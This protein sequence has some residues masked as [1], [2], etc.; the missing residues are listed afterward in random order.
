M[1]KILVILCLFAFSCQGKL[2]QE[3]AKTKVTALM[4][5]LKNHEYEKTKTYY[6]N[7]FNETESVELRKK[8]FEEIEAVSGKI[9]SY[10][11]GKVTE[12]T[13]DERDVLL[14]TAKVICE[15]T[16]LTEVFTVGQDEG[17]YKVLNHSITNLGADAT[18]MQKT[19]VENAPKKKK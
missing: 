1:K 18:G 6:D 7:A 12:Q 5:L 14:V 4:E 17:E 2:D 9:V 16:T 13:M 10:E 11:V 19:K 8:K 15:N 3:I